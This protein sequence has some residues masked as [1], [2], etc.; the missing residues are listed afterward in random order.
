MQDE[1]ASIMTAF[2]NETIILG[3]QG[4][5]IFVSSGDNGVA[6]TTAIGVCQC[7][8]NSGSNILSWN[9]RPFFFTRVCSKIF[10]CVYDVC[11]AV[12]E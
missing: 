4:V 7:N 12:E 2:N 11:F 1:S 8:R 6:D 3:A 5:T 9:V 10:A